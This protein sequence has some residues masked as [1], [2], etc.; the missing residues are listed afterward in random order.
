MPHYQAMRQTGGI[1][2][3]FDEETIAL[4]ASA[5]LCSPFDLN[6]FVL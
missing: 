1:Y 5:L 2:N 4:E 3:N 6:L